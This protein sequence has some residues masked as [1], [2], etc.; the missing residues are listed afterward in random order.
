VTEALLCLIF[1]ND[2]KSVTLSLFVHILRHYFSAETHCA[3]IVMP[4]HH[5]TVTGIQNVS[6]KSLKI[7]V[8][9]L[10]INNCRFVMI[11]CVTFHVS[12]P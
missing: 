5:W 9:L 8:R 4:L 7:Y 12:H 11:V 1:D 10:F 6:L 3:L 2:I